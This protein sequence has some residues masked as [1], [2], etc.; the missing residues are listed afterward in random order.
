MDLILWGNLFVFLGL[1]AY[2]IYRMLTS[3]ND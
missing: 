3:G 2:G 1:C